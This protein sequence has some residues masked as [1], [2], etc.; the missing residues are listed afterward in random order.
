MSTSTRALPACPPEPE[1]VRG[2]STFWILAWKAGALCRE[3]AS[4]VAE[5]AL[6]GLSV[7]LLYVGAYVPRVMAAV[8]GFHDPGLA[9][10]MLSCLVPVMLVLPFLTRP[11]PAG[12]RVMLAVGG[13]DL[14]GEYRLSCIGYL[15]RNSWLAFLVFF[16]ALP[17][18]LAV[19]GALLSALSLAVLCAAAYLADA[20]YAFSL[21]TRKG[22][23]GRIIPSICVL[24]AC[25]AALACLAVL[26]TARG[27]NL[28]A[29]ACLALPIPAWLG[30]F[31]PTTGGKRSVLYADYADH[32]SR[33]EEG[34]LTSLPR[35][36]P[37][38]GIFLDS[39]RRSPGSLAIIGFALFIELAAALDLSGSML[40]KMAD[41]ARIAARGRAAVLFCASLSSQALLGAFAESPRLF[42]RVLPLSFSAYARERYLP[43]LISAVLVSLPLSLTL[44][45]H[46]PKES[47][48]LLAFVLLPSLSATAIGDLKPLRG[49]VASA[50][51]AFCGI[52]LAFVSIGHASSPWPLSS[53]RPSYWSCLRAGTIIQRRSRNDPT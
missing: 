3:L 44:A 12:R 26:K 50:A 49:N 52:V 36:G 21:R 27:A 53:C 40:E 45:V 10:A 5:L 38:L 14:A 6:V 47:A 9:H 11:V 39:L 51:F 1:A 42:W 25:A 15:L 24:V 4:H 28:A 8:G 43:A 7:V 46:F 22:Q 35:V 41:P 2:T 30:F 31:S 33:H 20:L 16:A 23:A 13:L 19:D 32:A 29:S 34:R 48:L 37:R 18:Q 17:I